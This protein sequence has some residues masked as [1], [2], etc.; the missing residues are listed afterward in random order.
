MPKLQHMQ[1]LEAKAA[2]IFHRA[3]EVHDTGIMICDAV[4]NSPRVLLVND[5][6]TQLTDISSEE[7]CSK[8]LWQIFQI[9]GMPKEHTT[10]LGLVVQ[11]TQMSPVKRA[12]LPLQ[13]ST[14]WSVTG[15]LCSPT[16]RQHWSSALCHFK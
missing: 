4:G 9:K 15:S 2:Q 8:S 10:D 7:A 12:R 6:W 14:G 16:T 5:T 3:A 13:F 11:V 1:G